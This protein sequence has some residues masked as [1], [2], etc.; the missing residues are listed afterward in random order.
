[1]GIAIGVLI[2]QRIQ[3]RKNAKLVPAIE[4]ALREQG[5]LTLPALAEAVGLGG[6]L[7]RGRVAMAL[8]DLAAQKRLKT[9]P[10]PDGT[11]QLQKINFIKYELIG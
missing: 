5:A 4:A 9:I 2:A 10:A 1:M 8:N 7:A 11:P 6:F 3:R